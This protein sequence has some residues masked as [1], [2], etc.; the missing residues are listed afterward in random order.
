VL[1]SAESKKGSGQYY[2]TEGSILTTVVFP[3]AGGPS[4]Q[5]LGAMKP[6]YVICEH[7]DAK[8]QKSQP[9]SHYCTD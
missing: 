5:I 6:E 9:L 8:Q 3:E 4:T 2:N 1:S 7:Q